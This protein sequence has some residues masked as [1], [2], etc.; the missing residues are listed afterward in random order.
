MMVTLERSDKNLRDF[1]LPRTLLKM[2]SI[3]ISINFMLEN[4]SPYNSSTASY[5]L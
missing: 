3:L 5:K 1:V 4:G 2:V